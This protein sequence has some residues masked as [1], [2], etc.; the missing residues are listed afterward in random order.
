MTRNVQHALGGASRAMVGEHVRRGADPRRIQQHMG[1]RPPEPPRPELRRLGQIGHVEFHVGEAIA[2][3][4]MSRP[5]D[6]PRLAF[7][8]HHRS[9][10][11]RQRQGEVAEP[12]VQV[13]H[14]RLRRRPQQAPPRDSPA[15]DSG[16]RVHLHEV[17]GRELEREIECRQRVAERRC[18]WR[19]HGR[20]IHR[21]RDQLRDGVEPPGLQ[22]EANGVPR[23]K[24]AATSARSWRGRRSQHPQHQ[25]RGI[26]GHRHLDL[27]HMLA[28]S[29]APRSSAERLR[30]ASPTGARSTSQCATSAT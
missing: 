13:Q 20:A 6:Q 11:L 26:L 21:L 8:S 22:V 25:R 27:R 23:G 24:I 12:A 5:R 7:H 10:D 29:S 14:P 16:P 3:R 17:G 19:W 4:I 15:P 28:I 18:P 9:A 30:S 2:E 1:I